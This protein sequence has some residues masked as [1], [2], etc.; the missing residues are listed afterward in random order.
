MHCSH[1]NFSNFR[2]DSLEKLQWRKMEYSN[3]TTYYMF[4]LFILVF[5]VAANHVHSN[6][7]L[8][9]RSA[10][11]LKSTDSKNKIIEDNTF[12]THLR[13]EYIS[14]SWLFFLLLLLYRDK[15]HFGGKM[16]YNTICSSFI[17]IFA[18]FKFIQML[19]MWCFQY[20]AYF[21]SLLW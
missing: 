7:A 5:Y 13:N 3:I 18:L 14:N 11:R 6:F 20:K 17:H 9:R 10:L 4:F 16:K 19:Q 15:M 2:F 21:S 8:L 1:R 12:P